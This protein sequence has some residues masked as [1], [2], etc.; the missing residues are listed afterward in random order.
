MF[1][2][3]DLVLRNVIVKLRDGDYSTNVDVPRKHFYESLFGPHYDSR[4]ANKR[5]SYHQRRE[6]LALLAQT[7]FSTM[8]DLGV[9]TWIM[10]GSL[11]GWHW[12]RRILPWD[13]DVDVQITEES[14]H[15]LAQSHNMTVHQSKTTG[16]ESYC[17][18]LLEINPNYT[19]ITFDELN[20]ID[21]RWIDTNT[22]LYID[23]TTLRRNVTAEK[24]GLEGMMMSKDRHSYN[25]KD[26]FPLVNSTFEGVQV[27]VP[28][29]SVDVL[30][31]EY[32]ESATSQIY[33]NGFR[34]D[35]D[36][37]EWVQDDNA[38]TNTSFALKA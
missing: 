25:Y 34:F 35:R 9:E 18:Y 2:K 37:N 6:S 26:I 29:A 21:A 30:S 8:G 11:L 32:G 7:Y 33:H 13:S 38:G 28:S 31:K 23:I 10:H 17:S 22:G 20:M 15:Y 4:F 5:L 12:N 1:F 3:E 14:I 36:K 16:S 24:E 27:K 19:N